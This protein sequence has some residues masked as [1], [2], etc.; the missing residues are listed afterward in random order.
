MINVISVI[1]SINVINQHFFMLVNQASHRAR[2]V[3]R[4]KFG[5]I[6]SNRYR[7]YN[8]YTLTLHIEKKTL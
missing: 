1:K 7:F 2:G 3:T 6:P 5:K 4:G 8:E